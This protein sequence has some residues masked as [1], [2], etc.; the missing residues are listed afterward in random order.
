MKIGTLLT[1]LLLLAGSL[2]TAGCDSDLGI[3]G[4]HSP[5]P[6]ILRI[7]LKSADSDSMI[8]IAGDTVKVGE[9][10]ND[11]LGL[12]IA[13]GRAH[14]DGNFAVLF[15]GL[16][17]HLELSETYNM[18]AQENGMYVEFLIFETYLPPATYDSLRIVINADFLLIGT[19]QI[20]IVTPSDIGPIATFVQR[21]S[22]NENRITE[23]RLQLK[24]FKSLQR[25]GDAYHFFRDIEVSEI[26]NL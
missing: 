20:P 22:I 1:R 2:A 3:T 24:P 9:G 11:F 7:Y 16:D 8:V 4:V 19:F 17:E 26:I 12:T 21:F 13:Q 5:E 14:A 6:G 18:I 10:A 25:R 15:K 23:V